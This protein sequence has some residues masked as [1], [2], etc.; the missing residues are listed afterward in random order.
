VEVRY[1]GPETVSRE[2]ILAQMRT[3]VGQTYSDTIVEQDIRNLYATGQL[4]NVR[5]YGEPA[6][7][8][9]NV[10]VAVQ[11]R[12]SVRAIEINGATRMSA[13]SLR[14][15]IK[16]KMNGP[17]SEEAL[18]T[19]RQD[20]VDA[21]RAKGYNDIDVRYE[22]QTDQEH[23]TSRAVFTINEGVKGAVSRI[24]FAG[25]AHV[26]DYKLRKQMKTKTK[27]IISFLDKSGR[28]E[29][30][31]LNQDLDS[32]REY[33]QNQGYVDVEVKDVR[34]ERSGGRMTLVIPIVE[35]TK[36]H[37]GKI[38]VK[39]TKMTSAEKV[40][41]I[42]KI[43]EGAVYSP[44]EIREDAKKIADA[45]GSGGYVDLVVQPAGTP[46]GPGR[47]D[48]TFSIEEGNRAF[49]QRVNIVGNTRTKDKV[50]RR[51][52]LVTPGDI[53]STT[54][55][56]VS[57]K[58]LENLGYFS[59]VETYPDDTNV[60]G[61]KD[62]TVEVEEKR[63]GSLNFGAGFSTVDSFVGFV[64]LTQGNFDLM[65]WP[66]FTG[67]GQK[68][69]LRL[70][71][72]QQRKDFVL[73]LT[74][75]WF[76]DRPLSLGSELFYHEANFLSSVYDQRNYG[77]S[78]LARKPITRFLSM[79]LEYRLEEIDLFNVNRTVSNTI[80]I[81]K[82]AHTKSQITPSLIFE[83]RDN[84]F[85]TR[86][87]QRIVFTPFVAG[88]F[89]GGDTQ[90]FGGDI[91]ASQYF[92]LPADLILLVNGEVAAVDTW[93]NGKRSGIYGEGVPIF[94]RLFLGGSNNLRGFNFRD[95]GPKDKNGEPLGGRTLVRW[96]VEMTFPIIEKVRGAVFTDAGMVD[97]NAFD[98]GGRLSSDV[99][100]GLR[101][102]LPVGP[103]RIDY[104]FPIQTGGN[105]S[106][107]GK[108][109]F[110]VGYQF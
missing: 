103:I 22:V 88:G 65:N 48:V 18:G 34:R 75:P 36:Y 45:Y 104:G 71:G 96:T 43:K 70:Q 7:D 80:S 64:E 4:Q 56:E 107:A 44:K 52:V 81:D 108:F 83:T 110:N 31:Q 72:G 38:N 25:N 58:R 10:I 53:Y 100:I 3:K 87:G 20:I 46:S 109:N 33:Y 85:I 69:R 97:P 93:G 12:A 6:G 98:V 62:L 24:H 51:E 2:K 1:T 39:G 49:V 89:L 67:A 30:S 61:R 79:S 73:G 41:K 40:R 54:R 106:N 60:P 57:K 90:T 95:V 26:S 102:D 16:V 19:A 37:V 82:G 101:L 55:V 28:L 47:I 8:Q 66:T 76:L 17:L 29:E 23:G 99:G 13:K 94:D 11:T 14:K 86:K 27:T 15:M 84:P 92:H 77:I 9:V 5:I 78:I 68:F 59:H 74:E 32:I 50:I 63:T 91:E 35:G 42:L 21:Y 105:N